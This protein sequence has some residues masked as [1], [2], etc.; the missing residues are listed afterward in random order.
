MS[1]LVLGGA[2]YIGS[3]AVY[4]LI[5]Q[6]KQ[7]IVVDNLETG[8][9]EAVHPKAIFYQGDIR[10]ISFLR[11]VFAK[12][13]I[14]AVLHFAANSLVGESMENPLK[15]FDNNVYGTQI[16]LKVM[17]E[18][19]VKKSSS[20]PVLQPTVKQHPCQLQKKWTVFL[21]IPTVKLSSSWRSS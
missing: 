11:E 20:L 10:N 7:V 21:Q 4:Q 8:H 12:E 1:I 2:G 19:N 16:L 3:H 15:Y 9:P 18:H 17:I 5:D 13:S 14:D 6:G